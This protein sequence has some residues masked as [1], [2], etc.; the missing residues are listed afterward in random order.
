NLLPNN[1]L[2]MRLKK[3]AQKIHRMFPLHPVD[4]FTNLYKP[5]TDWYK[6]GTKHHF[7]TCLTSSKPA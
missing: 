5:C 1:K 2:P 4:L 6:I 7:F 3:Y